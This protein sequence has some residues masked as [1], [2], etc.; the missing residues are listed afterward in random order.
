MVLPFVVGFVVAVITNQLWMGPV[1]GLVKKLFPG[2]ATAVRTA[3]GPTSPTNTNDYTGEIPPVSLD[4]LDPNDKTKSITLNMS[5]ADVQLAAQRH[6]F[7]V[8]IA[9]NDG[10]GHCVQFKN[11]GGLKKLVHALAGSRQHVIHVNNGKGEEAGYPDFVEYL[12]FIALLTMEGGKMVVRP[13]Q[14]DR[15]DVEACMNEIASAGA[16][17][18]AASDAAHE[19]ALETSVTLAARMKPAHNGLVPL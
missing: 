17:S 2:A 14:A 13:L 19:T 11:G 12:P 3:A 1:N 15:N 4:E 6:G 8:Y 7:V 5:I 10:C 16:G 18:S 9:L